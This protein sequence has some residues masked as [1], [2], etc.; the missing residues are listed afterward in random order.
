MAQ[1]YSVDV[2]Q[3]LAYLHGK[4]IAHRDIKCDNILVE[5]NGSVKLADFG[6][7]KQA[8]AMCTVTGTVCFMAPE[9]VKGETYTLIADI[10]SYGCALIEMLSG[11]PPFSH[12]KNQHAIMYNMDKTDPLNEIPLTCSA[13]AR[14]HLTRCLQR[15]PNQRWTATQLLS[16][17]FLASYRPSKSTNLTSAVN[18]MKPPPPPPLVGSRAPSLVIERESSTT[19]KVQHQRF[20]AVNP[21]RLEPLQ[22]TR[23]VKTAE[24]RRSRRS[25]GSQLV[26]ASQVA[27]NPNSI[28]LNEPDGTQL[29]LETYRES[30]CG[31]DRRPTS[32]PVPE[33]SPIL[34]PPVS[35]RNKALSPLG[36]PLSSGVENDSSFFSNKQENDDHS[37]PSSNGSNKHLLCSPHDSPSSNNTKDV[38]QFRLAILRRLQP[39]PQQ[40]H[41]N[42]NPRAERGDKAPLVAQYNSDLMALH[43]LVEGGAANHNNTPS[44]LPNSPA[45]LVEPRDMIKSSLCSRITTRSPVPS[46]H[47]L[48]NILGKTTLAG[49][50]R[51]MIPSSGRLL[52]GR[53]NSLSSN[54]SRSSSPTKAQVMEL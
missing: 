23:K 16:H 6:Q 43:A 30:T 32:C 25:V 3:G 42:N 44:P 33:L 11:R 9:V 45:D 40:Q 13:R 7:S 38:E 5:T 8:S 27:K 1:G 46:L 24:E 47:E 15:D 12:F 53:L 52:T 20:R 49:S 31:A 29:I 41:R 19:Q 54:T 18:N 50:P 17:P 35:A 22:A 36:S 51:P 26:Q 10:W 2:V 39:S 28:T 34:S 48:S 14:D 37:P 4:H 21:A